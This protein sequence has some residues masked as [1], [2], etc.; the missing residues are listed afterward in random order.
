M[1]KTTKEYTMTPV[2]LM[3]VAEPGMSYGMQLVQSS[4]VGVTRDDFLDFIKQIKLSIQTLSE[5]IPASY[6]TLTK[7]GSSIKRRASVF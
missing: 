7:N 1:I 2:Q 6:S 3:Q 4:R 5:V